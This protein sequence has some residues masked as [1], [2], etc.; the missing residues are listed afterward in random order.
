MKLGHLPT[1]RVEAG[2]LTSRGDQPL[3][4][5]GLQSMTGRSNH[6][7]LFLMLSQRSVDTLMTVDITKA[8]YSNLLGVVHPLVL[9]LD[10][11]R[12]VQTRL[13]QV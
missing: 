13:H 7:T 4:P 3:Q 11:S 6:R 10:H 5:G 9:T 8:V 2:D 12:L 1:P